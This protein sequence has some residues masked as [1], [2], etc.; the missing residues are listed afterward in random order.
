M[1][2]FGP[3]LSHVRVCAQRELGWVSNVAVEFARIPASRSDVD[4]VP[5]A[6][7]SVRHII[8][9]GSCKGGVGKSTVTINLA[10]ALASM[11]ANVGVLD[12]DV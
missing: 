1:N 4:G 6:L 10:F 3:L 5:E 9:V 12:G 7:H 2:W 11:G 8:G